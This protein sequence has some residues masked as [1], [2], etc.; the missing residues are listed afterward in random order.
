MPNSGSHECAR[1]GERISANK[2]LCATCLDVMVEEAKHE[3]ILRRVI[4]SY[5]NPI[6]LEYA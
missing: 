3:A 2:F 4:D 1:C 5:D 6:N